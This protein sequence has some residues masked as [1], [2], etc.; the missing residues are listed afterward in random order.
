MSKANP[1]KSPLTEP[2]LHPAEQRLFSPYRVFLMALVASILMAVATVGGVIVAQ[3]TNWR[4]V[5]CSLVVCL[6][7]L[8]RG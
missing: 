2:L 4:I 1:Y 6:C 8:N 3:K 7:L 5:P